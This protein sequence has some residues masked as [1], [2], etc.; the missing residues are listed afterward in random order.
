MHLEE[1]LCVVFLHDVREDFNLADAEIRERFGDRIAD[2]VDV[3]TKVFRGCKKDPFKVFHA[4]GENPLASIAKGAD[5]IHNYGSMV[6]VFNYPKQIEYLDEGDIHFLPMLKNA[7]RAFPQQ[8]AAY[9]LI[10]LTLKSQMGLIREV[11]KAAG[12]VLRE[13]AAESIGE[14]V[15]RNAGG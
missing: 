14:F 3:M 8:E 2:A 6:G 5:R 1:T 10:K 12:I 9:E 13:E 7:R 4:I 11:H 15:K